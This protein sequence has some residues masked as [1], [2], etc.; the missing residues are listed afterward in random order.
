MRK[1]KHLWQIALRYL[2]PGSSLSFWYLPVSHD[3]QFEARGPGRYPVNFRRKAEYKGLDDNGIPIMDYGANIGRQYNACAIS[4]YALGLHALYLDSPTPQAKTLFLQQADWLKENQIESPAGIQGTWPLPFDMVGYRIK[5]PWISSL[6]QSQAISTLLRAEAISGDSSYRGAADLAFESI[7]T[8]TSQGG[9]TRFIGDHVIF[10]EAPSSPPSTVLDGF[11]YSFW[12][13][14]EYALATGSAEAEK[15][16]N[17][18]LDW[19][20]EN[21]EDY[22]IGFWSRADVY[23]KSPPCPASR[24][25][26]QVH[27]FLLSAIG[28][29]FI[30]NQ[31]QG[32]AAKWVRQDANLIY[33]NLAKIYKIAYKIIF[34]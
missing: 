19:L 32:Y 1:L 28:S 10:E 25:Y 2:R 17:G 18:A 16:I 9:V 20:K 26:H 30:D 3:P 8:P 7:R 5:G 23:R 14:Y 29:V 31:L 12:G 34:Y 21:I 15:M 11:L 22:D 4:Q 33:R 6:I 24:H 27:S 13:V